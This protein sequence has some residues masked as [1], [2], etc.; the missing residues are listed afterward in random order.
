MCYVYKAEDK[1]S[2][3]YVCFRFYNTLGRKT[4]VT[5]TSYLELITA[6]KTLINKKQD[7]TMKAK[8]RYVTGLEQLQF[9]GTQV[10]VNMYKGPCKLSLVMPK[11]DSLAIAMLAKEMAY[12]T[13]SLAKSL[14]KICLFPHG[15][16]IAKE[17]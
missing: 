4:Y 2:L 8:K 1:L 9:A 12:P 6:F 5:P 10:G 3:T 16:A 17:A 14:V 7:E 15:T 13:H 11:S